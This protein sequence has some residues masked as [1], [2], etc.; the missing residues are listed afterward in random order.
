MKPADERRQHMGTL[1]VEVVVRLVEIRGYGGDEIAAIL[2]SIGLAHFNVGDLGYGV[3]LI[4]LFER[5]GQQILFLNR[6][7][8]VP[9]INA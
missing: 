4:G 5:T 2:A 8:A 1:Q 3:L 9:W 7:G 6:L